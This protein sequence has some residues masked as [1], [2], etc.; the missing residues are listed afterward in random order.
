MLMGEM[1]F[2]KYIDNPSGGSVIPNRNMYREMYAK[3]FDALM[4]REEGKTNYTVYKDKDDYY[5]HLKVPSEAV[6]NYYYDV[7]VRLYTKDPAKKVNMNLRQHAVQFFSNDPAFVYTF[8]YAFKHKDIFVKD[9]SSKLSRKTLSNK[10]NNNEART[11]NVNHEIFYVKSLFFA[12]IIM[13]KE[14]LFDRN[15]LDQIAVKYSKS[16]LLNE[17]MSFEEKNDERQSKK[18]EQDKPKNEK[19]PT[20]IDKSKPVNKWAHGGVTKTSQ[21][22][23]TSTI[24]KMVKKTKTTKTMK[25]K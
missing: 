6:F 8:A 20:K 5:I 14:N 4:V 17:V 24:S 1:T 19:Q 22:A 11:R 21:V 16:K 12:Y 10:F 18:F 23:K 7:V 13:D 25:R 3:K 9:L 15:K 2:D